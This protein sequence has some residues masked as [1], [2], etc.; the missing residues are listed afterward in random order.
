MNTK[1]FLNER[2]KNTFL[3]N[4]MVKLRHWL[5]FGNK[6][7]HIYFGVGGPYLTDESNIM[8][9]GYVAEMILIT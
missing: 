8:N 6:I 5:T 9:M 2:S 7:S 3:R 4:D 1:H